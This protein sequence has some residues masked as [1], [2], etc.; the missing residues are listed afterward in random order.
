MKPRHMLWGLLIL[1]V[2]ALGCNKVNKGDDDNKGTSSEDA[3]LQTDSG[4]VPGDTSSSTGIDTTSS[5]GVDTSSSSASVSDTTSGTGVGPNPDGTCAYDC[6]SAC[7]SEG[8]VRRE[9]FCSGDLLCCDLTPDRPTD[10]PYTDADVD[11]DGDADTDADGDMDTDADSDTD[12]DACHEYMSKSDDWCDRSL[13]CPNSY[14]WANCDLQDEKCWCEGSNG[15][16]DFN[17]PDGAGD[18]PCEFVID[19]CGDINPENT[20]E[21]ECGS[22]KES[23]DEWYCEISQECTQTVQLTPEITTQM[24]SWNYTNCY[25]EDEWGDDADANWW[26]ECSG[27]GNYINYQVTVPDGSAPCNA[28][29]DACQGGAEIVPEGDVVCDKT[30]MYQDRGR[31]CSVGYT[32]ELSGNLSDTQIAMRGYMDANCERNSDGEWECYCYGGNR[33]ETF[34]LAGTDAWDVCEEAGPKC[35]D[36]Y[37]SE[38]LVQTGNGRY[39]PGMDSILIE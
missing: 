13:E 16:F 25:V 6:V 3:T 17:L 8:G 9:G 4:G 20:G 28:V 7:T 36:M 15:S 27:N 26:C 32:C 33:E 39:Y 22:R 31:Y 2:F 11:I 37:T 1:L 14:L 5:S 23:R 12:A 34:I 24:N 21:P 35:M 30:N 38:E 19:I 29:Y 18:D 10:L